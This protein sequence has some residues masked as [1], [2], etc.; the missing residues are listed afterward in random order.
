[1]GGGRAGERRSGRGARGRAVDVL[2]PALHIIA[3]PMSQRTFRLAIV[4]VA[5]LLL[6]ACSQSLT[7]PAAV[8]DGHRISQDALRG[9]I[10]LALTNPQAAQTDGGRQDLTRRVLLSMIRLRIVQEYADTHHIT[11]GPSDVDQELQR[12]VTQAGGQASF[13]QQLKAQH[14]TMAQARF[15]VARDVLFTKVQDAVALQRLG[16]ASSDAQ[17]RGQVFTQWLQQ[18]FTTAAIEVNPRFGRLDT[19]QG[20]ITPIT[21]TA[22]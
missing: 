17:Q 3:G 6:S 22:G 14:L 7:P 12:F 1:M 2:A 4:L 5:C 19:K 15:I 13:D 20:A 9:E 11:V 18:R 8:V 16:P 21:S 10:D